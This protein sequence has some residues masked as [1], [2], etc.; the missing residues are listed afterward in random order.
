[1]RIATTDHAER[2][3]ASLMGP[4]L[5]SGWGIRTIGSLEARYNPMSYHNVNAG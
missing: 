4:A 1:L 3:A 5:F 2:V